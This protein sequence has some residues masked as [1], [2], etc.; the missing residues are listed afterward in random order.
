MNYNKKTQRKKSEAAAAVER[1]S[2]PAIPSAYLKNP[3]YAK[4]MGV[5]VIPGQALNIAKFE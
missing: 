5:T 1:E 3:K 4:A 2:P